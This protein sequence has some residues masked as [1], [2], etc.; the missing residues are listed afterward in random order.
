MDSIFI[1][2]HDRYAMILEYQPGIGPVRQIERASLHPE[3]DEKGFY[4]E[5]GGVFIGEFAS[6]RGPVF[7]YGKREYFLADIRYTAEVQKKTE[8]YI[9]LLKYDNE[10]CVKVKY[11][12]VKYK[13]YDNWSDEISLDFFL[14]LA[15]ALKPHRRERFVQYRTLS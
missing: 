1:R 2:N 6:E 3:T 12:P 8:E 5:M 14:W 13:D 10:I 7:F 11:P 9:F 15:D 4:V